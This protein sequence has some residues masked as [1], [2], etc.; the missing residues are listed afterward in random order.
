MLNYV[1]LDMW[2]RLSEEHRS[3]ITADAFLMTVIKLKY[4]N[5]NTRQFYANDGVFTDDRDQV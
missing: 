2:P 3:P 1:L 4:V 5:K